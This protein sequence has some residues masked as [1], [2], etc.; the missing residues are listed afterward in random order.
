MVDFFYFPPKLCLEQGVWVKNKRSQ[1]EK[2]NCQE[3]EDQQYVYIKLIP[4]LPI[5]VGTRTSHSAFIHCAQPG[6]YRTDWY[7]VCEWGGM[8]ASS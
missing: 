3:A 6:V 8:A 1:S 7:L 2:L 5:R 4:D